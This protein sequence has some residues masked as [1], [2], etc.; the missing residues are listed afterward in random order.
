M[1][2]PPS[3]ADTARAGTGGL[4][5]RIALI[6]FMGSGKSTVGRLLAHA[7]G[8]H[9]VDLDDR[10]EA[11]AGRTIGQIFA[12]EGEESFRRREAEA[13]ESLASE[14]EVVAAGGGGAPVSAGNQGFFSGVATTFY[15]EVSFEEF[16]RRAGSDPARPLLRRGMGELRSL[17]EARRPIYE[18]LGRRIPTD[19]RRADEV[20]QEIL[21]ILGR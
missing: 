4:P 5:P 2:G 11:E 14:E 9:F 7:L 15:L 21:E 17:Y 6:G 1:G 18:R 3:S 19:G 20:A 12:E 8:Y 10:I 16:V 13:L